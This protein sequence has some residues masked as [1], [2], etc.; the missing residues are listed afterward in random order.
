MLAADIAEYS[1]LMGADEEGTLARLKAVRKGIVDPAITSYRGH[2][3]KTTG[4]GMLVEF[5]SAVDAVR[6]AVE[7][8]R[9]MAQQNAAAPQNERIEFRIGFT[10]VM[11]FSMTTTSSAMA[12]TL[13]PDLRA[14]LTRA[15]SAFLMM[16]IGRSGAR[17]RLPV[18]IWDRSPSRILLSLCECGGF[19]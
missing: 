1:R 19:D 2:I 9:C 14:S 7:V 13:L 5:A 16:P 11:S 6:H 4:D 18:M 10:S 15:G 8:Q 12:S 3:V 17:S